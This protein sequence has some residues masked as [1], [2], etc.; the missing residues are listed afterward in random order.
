DITAAAAT[1]LVEMRREVHLPT[2]GTRADDSAS[3]RI[4][5]GAAAPC[6]EGRESVEPRPVTSR[7]MN[8][9]FGRSSVPACEDRV[10][11]PTVL[12]IRN[13]RKSF[14]TLV[15]VDDVSFSLEPGQLVGLLA[16]N[17]AGK[18]TTLSTTTDLT[19]PAPPALP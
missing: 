17:G 14:G 4:P 8:P 19:P 10:R 13:L 3:R 7:P 16:P 12:T 2:C 11:V 6:G 9:A 18:P 1:G 15:A 5:S